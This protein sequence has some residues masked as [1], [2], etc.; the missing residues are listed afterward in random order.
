MTIEK[1]DHVQLAMPPGQED[2]A[3]QFYLG[4][5]GLVEVR[6]PPSLVFR[7]GAWFERGEVRVHLGSRA[8]S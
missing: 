6:K 2:L 3:R 5:L 1:L 7:G 8:A 4:A